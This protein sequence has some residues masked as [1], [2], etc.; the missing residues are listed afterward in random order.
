MW[1]TLRGRGVTVDHEL[2]NVEKCVE[3]HTLH[4][5]FVAKAI[6]KDCKCLQSAVDVS[7]TLPLQF[8]RPEV[9]VMRA[10]STDES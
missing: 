3:E 9:A 4:S 6:R 2:C 5:T 10:E 7:V 8:E 1:L